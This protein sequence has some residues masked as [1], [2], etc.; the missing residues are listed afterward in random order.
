MAVPYPENGGNFTPS[1]CQLLR[2]QNASVGIGLIELTVSSDTLNYKPFFK[3]CILKTILPVILLFIF[4]WN[5]IIFSKNQTVFY[6]FFIWFG[7][8]FGVTVLK[9]LYF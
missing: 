7:V 8:S 1:P 5:E 4:V 6:I 2:N 9:V 3:H